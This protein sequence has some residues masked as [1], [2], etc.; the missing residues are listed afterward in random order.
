[1]KKLTKELK[2]KMLQAE[3]TFRLISDELPKEEK[4]K[5]FFAGYINCLVDKG[6]INTKR[7]EGY[8]IMVSEFLETADL[9]QNSSEW[10]PDE[11]REEA[12]EEAIS[13]CIKN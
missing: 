9:S 2:L 6:D 8:R 1:M 11:A 10:K 7:A 13:G 5:S 3:H 4:F 12:L